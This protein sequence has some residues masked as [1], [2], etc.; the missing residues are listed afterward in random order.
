MAVKRTTT[1]P[2]LAKEINA[3]ISR[4]DALWECN[5]GL[6]VK[7][8]VLNDERNAIHK[9]VRD[10]R[11]FAEEALKQV[12]Q[13]RMEVNGRKSDNQKVLDRLAAVIDKLEAE[14]VKAQDSMNAA[15]KEAD[16]RLKATNNDMN[17]RFRRTMTKTQEFEARIS[18]LEEELRGN[19]PKIAP[20]PKPAMT[21]TAAFLALPMPGRLR[22]ISYSF[23]FDSEY[24]KALCEAADMLD[25]KSCLPKPVIL[26][27]NDN[28]TGEPIPCAT[29]GPYV[30]KMTALD[31][32]QE[33]KT[34]NEKSTAA[35]SKYT[36]RLVPHGD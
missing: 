2:A 33:Y 23:P 18:S 6:A 36:Y 10:A 26:I 17:E 30:E 16:D 25:R 22:N 11:A 20:A 4:L 5:N 24:S 12:V 31:K 7:V 9:D 21:P 27:I 29:F 8:M 35:M 34:R 3:M 28:T 14:W 32:Y 1:G 19:K 13:T 15:L